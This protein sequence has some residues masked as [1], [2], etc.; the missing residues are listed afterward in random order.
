MGPALLALSFLWTMA[1]TEDTCPGDSLTYHN[2][3]PFSTKDQD[4][5]RDAKN[6]A[7]HYHGAWWYASCHLSNLN[8]GYLGGTHDS[9]ANGI[10]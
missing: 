1:L 6:C 10:N 9:F 8:G 3:Y 4:N 2:N 7:V 5:D